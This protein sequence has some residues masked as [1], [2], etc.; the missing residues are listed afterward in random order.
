MNWLEQE[1]YDSLV[2]KAKKYFRESVVEIKK[3]ITTE[4]EKHMSTL[5]ES[6]DRL[7]ADIK[8]EIQQVRDEAA[9]NLQAAQDA[10]AA[11]DA[12]NTELTAA[13]QTQVDAN[14]SLLDTIDGAQGRLDELS[15]GLEANDPAPAPVDPPVD[16]NA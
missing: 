15:T 13:L 11:A 2:S 14:Q 5:N 10:L 6:I 1:G 7:S 3:H 9:A 16:P 4:L 8:T 12:Q